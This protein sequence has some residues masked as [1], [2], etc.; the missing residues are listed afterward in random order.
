MS[1]FSF[2]SQNSSKR[3]LHSSPKR[4]FSQPEPRLNRPSWPFYF[5]DI[6]PLTKFFKK[7]CIDSVAVSK[8]YYLCHRKNDE[9]VHWKYAD[10]AQLVEQLICNQPVV[11][12]SP[13]IGSRHKRN[14]MGEFQSGQMGQTVNL[15]AKPSEVRI[16]PLP[17]NCG[18]SSFGRAT[19]FQ[20]V[21]GGFEPRFPLILQ[22]ITFR[23]VTMWRLFLYLCRLERL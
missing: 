10:I 23:A 15:L 11:G 5:C 1:V 21:G 4:R 19:A 22:Q 18:S 20:A 9:D 12:S 2:F 3:R 13:T 14:N 17:L 16:L 7:N 8:K 6:Q